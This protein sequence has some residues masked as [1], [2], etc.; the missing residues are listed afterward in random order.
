[1]RP[2]RLYDAIEAGAAHLDGPALKD[3]INGP[4]AIRD[5]AKADTERA[6]ATLQNS[7]RTAAAVAAPIQGTEMAGRS[8]RSRELRLLYSPPKWL[9]RT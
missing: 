1:M 9:M 2:K 5:Q 3:R 4:S 6:Q 7:G 8:R